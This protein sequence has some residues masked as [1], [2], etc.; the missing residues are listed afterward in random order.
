MRALGAFL[1]LIATS[2]AISDYYSPVFGPLSLFGNLSVVTRVWLVFVASCGVF[3]LFFPNSIR[4]LGERRRLRRQSGSAWA[5]PPNIESSIRTIGEMRKGVNNLDVFRSLTLLFFVIL[6]L[7]IPLDLANILHDVLPPYSTGVGLALL[8]IL[9]VSVGGPIL[10][11]IYA[12][13]RRSGL[14]IQSLERAAQA[15]EWRFRS[16][17]Q[18]FWQRY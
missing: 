7:S 13:A 5:A 8:G 14:R 6:A 2:T 17:E 12:W 11:L 4:A 16:L 15:A 3:V 9:Y 18:V 10:F 1:V